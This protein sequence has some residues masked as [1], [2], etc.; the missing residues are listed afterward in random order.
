[1]HAGLRQAVRRRAR[2]C[3]EY[4]ALPQA[5]E[6]LPFHVEHVLARQHGGADSEENLALAGHHCN[7]HKGPNLAGLDP[8]TGTLTRLFNPRRDDWTSH[9]SKS[10]G[11]IT[12]LTDVGRTTVQLLEMN[13]NGR[14]ELR[15]A[16]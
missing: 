5:S 14:K 12:G 13:S 6:P 7:L 8:S 2:N 15:A 4:C 9:F 16:Q 10:G 1:M 11:E 3:C